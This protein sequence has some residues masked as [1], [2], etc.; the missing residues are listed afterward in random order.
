M[1]AY[2]FADAFPAGQFFGV[3]EQ[4]GCQY[5]ILAETGDCFSHQQFVMPRIEHDITIHLCRIEERAARF[6]RFPDRVKSVTL[7]GY[8]AIAVGKPH[9]AHSYFGNFE[10]SN[11]SFLHRV[12]VFELRCKI[13][14]EQIYKGCENRGA[15]SLFVVFAYLCRIGKLRYGRKRL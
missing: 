3:D 14:E 8:F 5:D 6:I 7:F 2:C 1:C 9:A 15:F 10:I 4:F 13:T 12:L 11:H